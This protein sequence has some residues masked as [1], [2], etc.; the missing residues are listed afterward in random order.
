MAYSSIPEFSNIEISESIIG[1]PLNE[2]IKKITP[3]IT[4]EQLYII[5]NE[6][7]NCYDHSSFSRTRL[8]EGVLN[9]IQNLRY[10]NIKLFIATNKPF[11]VT[12]KILKNLMI[13]DFDDIVSLD[14]LT[15]KKMDK[16]EMI[17]YITNKWNLEQDATLM[18]GDDASDILA[19]QKNGLKSIAIANGYGSLNEIQK[20]KPLYVI[21]SIN[22]VYNIL[23]GA[24]NEVFFGS[25]DKI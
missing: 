3:D 20:A 23:F 17:A 21:D 2:I 16:S 13:D 14:V 15:G 22:E 6:F 9:L 11:F 7:R 8:N 4:K 5:I 19:A 1:P 12:N 24:S 18:V 25:N 10:R